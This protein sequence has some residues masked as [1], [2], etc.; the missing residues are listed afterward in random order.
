MVRTGLHSWFS[1][2]DLLNTYYCWSHPIRDPIVGNIVF[3]NHYYRPMGELLLACLYAVFGFNPGP[4]NIVRLVLCAADVVVLYVFAARLTRSREAGVLSVMLA[5]FH[6]VMASLYYDSGMLFDVLA[7]L[8]Y[9]AAFG[10]Y[11]HYRRDGRFPGVLQTVWVLLLYIGALD[12]KEIAVSF[13]VGLLLYE[14]VVRRREPLLRRCL[15]PLLGG[16]L[17][18]IYLIGKNTGPDALNLQAAYHPLISLPKYLDTYASYAAQFILQPRVSNPVMASALLG[19]I[20]LALLLRNPILTWA[21]LFNLV[22]ILPIAFIP[23][24]NG[25]IFFVPLAG[26]AI[27][28]SVLLA[29]IRDAV[30]LHRGSLRLPAQ[31]TLA[32]ALCLVVLRPETRGAN[33]FLF[34]IV[35]NEQNRNLAAWNSLRASLPASVHDKKILALRDPFQNGYT[36]YFLIQLGYN[37]S[38]VIVYTRR[39]QNERNQPIVPKDYDAV[40]DYDDGKFFRVPESAF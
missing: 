21:S 25:F 27:Y 30:I 1:S 24:R 17:T 37:D 15:V 34:P 32:A 20:A 8:F 40:V 4:F 35:H 39:L 2:D 14:L 18:L 11:L 31:I 19:C 23:T 38:T 12:S 5:G 3:F 9:Y 22:A 13:P 26:W 28:A 6:P 29:E 36:L 16:M 10:L 7:F 33:R